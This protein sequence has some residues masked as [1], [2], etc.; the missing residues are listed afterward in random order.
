[1]AL[2]TKDGTRQIRTNINESEL[3]SGS[4]NGLYTDAPDSFELSDITLDGVQLVREHYNVPVYFNSTGRS[5]QQ[6]T[7]IGGA[8]KSKHLFS[9]EDSNVEAID[10]RFKDQNTVGS[11]GNLASIDYYNQVKNQKGVLY[12]K[13]VAKGIKGFGLYDNFNHTDSR[14]QTRVSLWDNS[15]KKKSYTESLTSSFQNNEDGVLDWQKSI[16]VIVIIIILIAIGTLLYF[17]LKK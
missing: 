4:W 2:I 14:N 7:A 6:N 16:T 10:W 11:A 12:D 15:T 8:S 1:M 9:F 5:P 17:K 13:L 3:Q